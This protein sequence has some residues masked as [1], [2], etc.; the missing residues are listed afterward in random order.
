MTMISCSSMTYQFFRS[1]PGQ[2]EQ[3]H[4]VLALRW[5]LRGIVQGSAIKM[6]L[7]TIAPFL[8]VKTGK[9]W[10]MPIEGDTKFHCLKPYSTDSQGEPLLQHTPGQPLAAKLIDFLTSPTLVEEGNSIQERINDI[11]T[12]KKMQERE[13]EGKIAYN[14]FGED[15][16][17]LID[18]VRDLEDSA[19]DRWKD[20]IAAILGQVE[21]LNCNDTPKSQLSQL[22]EIL[23]MLETLKGSFKLYKRLQPNS[24]LSLG[25]ILPAQVIAKYVVAV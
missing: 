4:Q 15:V 7:V 3:L 10:P 8:E 13:I 23:D 22:K 12:T 16:K 21:A 2:V 20:Y 19:S 17:I 24:P 14:D 5:A 6:H 9:F 1:L 18:W 25:K 11:D